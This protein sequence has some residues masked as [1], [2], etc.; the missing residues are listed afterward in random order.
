MRIII[1]LFFVS[2][3]LNSCKR[4][5]YS[6]N[7]KQSILFD[8]VMKIHDDVMPKTADINRIQRKLKKHLKSNGEQMDATQKE[9]ILTTLDQLT[10]AD[11]MMYDWMKKFEAPKSTVKE[12]EALQYLQ[13]EKDK[14]SKVSE[15][16]LSSIDKGTKLLEQLK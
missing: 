14:I 8:E 2:L 12:A 10:K 9:N 5:P 13:S 7:S 1:V 6:E 16:M 11:D 3:C 15:A 4:N